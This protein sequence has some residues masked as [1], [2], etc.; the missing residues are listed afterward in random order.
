MLFNKKKF[1]INLIKIMLRNIDNLKLYFLSCFK[2]KA[3]ETPARTKD[4]PM[5]FCYVSIK[6]LSRFINQFKYLKNI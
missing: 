5:S 6:Y 1:K 3:L 4:K 2:V